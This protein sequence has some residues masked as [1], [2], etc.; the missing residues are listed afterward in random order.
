MI[1]RGKKAGLSARASTWQW[2]W[3]KRHQRT[4]AQPTHLN[5]NQQV[6]LVTKKDT[7]HTRKPSWG[8]RHGLGNFWKKTNSPS[9]KLGHWTWLNIYPKEN[10][11]SWKKLLNTEMLNLIRKFK[12]SVAKIQ[13]ML[14]FVHI[15]VKWMKIWTH[16]IWTSS[17]WNLTLWQTSCHMVFSN[18]TFLVL[19]LEEWVLDRSCRFSSSSGCTASWLC[20]SSVS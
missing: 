9:R 19:T 15:S 6:S 7:Q 3:L 18:S 11:L 8:S 17:L 5:I 13:R 20:G 4:Q 10:K 12:R 14:Q 2:T 16:C 1:V